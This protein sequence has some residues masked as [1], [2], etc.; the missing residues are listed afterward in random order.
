VH[1]LELSRHGARAPVSGKYNWTKSYWEEGYG[2][3]SPMGERQH[4]LIGAEF[5]ERYVDEKILGTHYDPETIEVY[6]SA[7]NRTIESAESQLTGLFPMGTG[8]KLTSEQ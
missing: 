7:V 6:S 5:R 2:N 3:L 8:P 4:Y 1:V